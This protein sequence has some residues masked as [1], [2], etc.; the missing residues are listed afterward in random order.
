MT[1]TS[2]VVPIP[3]R[4]IGVLGEKSFNADSSNRS[5]AVNARG[6]VRQNVVG[7][8]EDEPV[9]SEAPTA[10]RKN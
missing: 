3:V 2:T 1:A 4:P 8:R 10:T 6:V 9:G 5:E 7:R